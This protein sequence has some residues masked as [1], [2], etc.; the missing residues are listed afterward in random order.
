MNVIAARTMLLTSIERDRG[1]PAG[2]IA[3]SA[4]LSQPN[5]SEANPAWQQLSSGR[6]APA[7]SV[8]KL[9]SRKFPGGYRQ[10]YQQSGRRSGVRR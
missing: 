2:Q 1:M 9:S 4:I 7:N 8:A 6:V 3:R 10:R 5:Q